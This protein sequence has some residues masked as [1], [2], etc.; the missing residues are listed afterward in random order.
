MD[1]KPYIFVYSQENIYFGGWKN[2]CF[3]QL[4]ELPFLL[5]PFRQRAVIFFAYGETPHL[6][7]KG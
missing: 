7:L 2:A 1:L 3:A 4:S 6:A 5:P